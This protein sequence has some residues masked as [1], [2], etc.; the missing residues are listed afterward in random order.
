MCWPLTTLVLFLALAVPPHSRS[1]LQL[2]AE[3]VVLSPKGA[4]SSDRGIS[5][6]FFPLLQAW[7]TEAHV[8][9]IF[10]F[11]TSC[12]VLQ[13]PSQL[14]KLWPYISDQVVTRA[15]VGSVPCFLYTSVILPFSILYQNFHFNRNASQY[16]MIKHHMEN[17][18]PLR[19]VYRFAP[20]RPMW[21]DGW[22][23]LLFPNP[24]PSLGNFGEVDFA[25][26]FFMF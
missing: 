22:R 8:C 26:F 3:L 4:I 16:T 17:K 23:D 7:H 12:S 14:W 1:L 6:C 13:L 18:A 19:P 21:V 15:C 2:S 10:S 24:S 25:F 20:P 9:A 11:P 5:S